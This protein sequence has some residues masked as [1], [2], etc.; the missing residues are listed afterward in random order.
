MTFICINHDQNRIL[1]C[2]MH[3][4]KI[5]ILY[6]VLTDI[7]IVTYVSKIWWLFIN[8]VWYMIL[9]FSSNNPE[10]NRLLNFC[11]AYILKS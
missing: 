10:H 9:I 4:I 7:Y 3:V 2:L 1:K 8:G 11:L 6:I 5:Y